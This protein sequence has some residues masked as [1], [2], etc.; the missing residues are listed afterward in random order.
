MFVKKGNFAWVIALARTSVTLW[1]GLS[2]LGASGCAAAIGDDAM[3]ESTPITV[4]S[5]NFP[6][7]VRPDSTYV[8]SLT[9]CYICLYEEVSAHAKYPWRDYYCTYNPGSDLNELHYVPKIPVKGA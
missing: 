4:N 6:T 3:R 7:F 8:T 5:C 1:L 2:V 9:N